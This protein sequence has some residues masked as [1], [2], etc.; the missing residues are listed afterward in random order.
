MTNTA[1]DLNEAAGAIVVFLMIVPIF[2]DYF[3]FVFDVFFIYFYLLIFFD[4]FVLFIRCFP[5]R[6]LDR[7]FDIFRLFS[8]C[9]AGFSVLFD[10]ISHFLSM[11][12]ILFD[13]LSMISDFVGVSGSGQPFVRQP[14]RNPSGRPLPGLHASAMAT[15]RC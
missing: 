8:T 13:V 5:R 11:C 9:F 1:R 7:F 15:L 3:G 14:S 12:S 4:D 2:L 10:D 6:D